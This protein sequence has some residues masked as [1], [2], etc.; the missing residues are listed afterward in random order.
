M[1]DAHLTVRLPADLARALARWARARDVP[2]SQVVREALAQYIAPASSPDE[3]HAQRLSARELA[4]CWPQLPRLGPE[5]AGA[6]A[7][8]VA[9]GREELPAV[10][11]AWE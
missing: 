11:A 7:A 4:E 9:A 1:T 2:R 6:L 5:D 8:D 10:R 3:R